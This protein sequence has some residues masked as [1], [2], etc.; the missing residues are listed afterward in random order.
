MEK[1]IKILLIHTRNIFEQDGA[2][3]NR[4]RTMIEGLANEGVEIQIIFT[5]GFGSVWEFK[6]YGWQGKIVDITYS[7]TIFL[8][9]NTL[10][11]RRISMYMLSPLLKKLNILRTRKK[12]KEYKPDIVWLLSAIEVF[13]IY[14]GAIGKDTNPEYQLMIELNEFNDNGLVNSTNKLQLEISK[15]YSN[16]LLFEILPK[17]DL[18][19]IMTR[20]LLY[21]YRKFTDADRAKFLHLPMTVDLKRFNFKRKPVSRYIAYCGS[22]SFVKDGVDILLQ[23][24]SIVADKYPDVK[25]KIAAFMEADGGKMLALINELHLKDKVEYVGE[26]RRDEIPDFI[27][28]AELLILPRP[29]SRQAQGGFPT[30]L[31]EYLASGNPVCVTVVGEIPDYLVDNESA[32]MAEPGSVVS[33]VSAI[34]K[35]LSDPVN[36]ERVGL[37]GRKVAEEHFNMNIQ[38][39]LL[40][41]FLV[42]NRLSV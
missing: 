23:S 5:Q 20:H 30:K 18:L 35:A 24:F 12:I 1:P 16:V 37:N 42:K 7:Y 10:L 8:L 6:K 14:L 25:L 27:T 41:D 13:D 22:S 38:S 11:M 19:L 17:M 40:F 31:G 29:N 2:G 34:D 28:N 39:K 4:W 15:R 21:H 26:L 36:A 9:H 33:L 32:F 3:A